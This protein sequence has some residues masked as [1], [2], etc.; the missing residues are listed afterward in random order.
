MYARNFWTGSTYDNQF[1]AYNDAELPTSW[2][3]GLAGGTTTANYD[4]QGR[5]TT[6]NGGFGGITTAQIWKRRRHPALHD[7][8][9]KQRSD[10]QLDD[11]GARRQRGPVGI[12]VGSAGPGRR[13]GEG[14]S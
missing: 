2:G 1:I 9:S 10:R 11:A 4:D 12:G 5:Q 14:G 8:H 13:V 7:D 3:N 6:S